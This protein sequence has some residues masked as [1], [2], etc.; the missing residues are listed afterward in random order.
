MNTKKADLLTQNANRLKERAALV[1]VVAAAEAYDVPR[2]SSF[3]KEVC[4]CV[5][6]YDRL[7]YS[8]GPVFCVRFLFLRVCVCVF[9]MPHFFSLSCPRGRPFARVKWIHLVVYVQLP[10]GR[11][12]CAV[13]FFWRPGL[14]PISDSILVIHYCTVFIFLF[15]YHEPVRERLIIYRGVCVR[16]RA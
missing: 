12:I 6:D 14:S 7:C 11:L 3:L 13:V 10:H 15:F 16:S 4:V 1:A 9:L 2:A 8:F 5:C